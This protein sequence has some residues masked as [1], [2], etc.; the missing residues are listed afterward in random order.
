MIEYVQVTAEGATERV[1]A[2]VTWRA[3]TRPVLP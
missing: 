3:A 2:T 1:Q